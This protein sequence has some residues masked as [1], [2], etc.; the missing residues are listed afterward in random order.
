MKVRFETYS[1]RFADQIFN[2]MFHLRD[3][4]FNILKASFEN[5]DITIAT[6]PLLNE[7]LKQNF[8]KFG[9]TSQPQIFENQNDIYAKLDFLKARL[10]VEVQFGHSSF[11]G[12]DV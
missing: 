12:I 1:Y 6:R 2:G 11:I 7:V 8:E 10:G 5:A 4:F 3:E 9:W